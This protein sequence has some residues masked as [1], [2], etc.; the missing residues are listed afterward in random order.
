M[1]LHVAD[2]EGI[3]EGCVLSIRA[4]TT[5][6]QAQ[7]NADRPFRFPL[8]LAEATP[9][10]VD[11]LEPVASA[12]FILRPGDEEHPDCQFTVSLDANGGSLA[13]AAS[14]ETDMGLTFALS[15]DLT[16][17]AH[18]A[19]ALP[20]GLD[21]DGEGKEDMSRRSSRAHQIAT[22]EYLD[23]HNLVEFTQ[24]LVQAVIKEQPDRPYAFMA[25]HF[26]FPEP[27]PKC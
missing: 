23:R 20:E 27:V 14:T 11:V 2:T 24:H 4:G 21:E 25:S 1:E 12:K 9:F 19:A 13:P 5:R 10:K 17:K 18:A 22:R 15:S 7:A 8:G 26:S 3:P 6:R 16:A